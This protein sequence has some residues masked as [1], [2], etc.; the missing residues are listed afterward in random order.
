MQRITEKKPFTRFAK[1]EL[2]RSGQPRVNCV[3][4][5]PDIKDKHLKKHFSVLNFITIIVYFKK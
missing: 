5:D 2:P 1:A 4:E 3:G